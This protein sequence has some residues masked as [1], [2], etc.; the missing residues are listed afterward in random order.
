M[1]CT[2]QKDVSWA[3]RT[4]FLEGVPRY[5]LIAA[6][7]GRKKSPSECCIDNAFRKGHI[8]SADW[9]A[10]R[11]GF[12]LCTNLSA[13][14]KVIRTLKLDYGPCPSFWDTSTWDP[15]F[16][17]VPILDF[18]YCPA[19]LSVSLILQISP[20]CLTRSWDWDS[21]E[22]IQKAGAKNYDEENDR[23]I[24]NDKRREKRLIKKRYTKHAKSSRYDE[25]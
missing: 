9:T 16:T 13:V 7:H 17:N 5:I 10:L 11:S 1:S 20:T 3:Y 24:E 22:C 18:R 12:K 2:S 25:A 4:D 23:R 14:G 6:S 15:S 8:A 21:F 19:H